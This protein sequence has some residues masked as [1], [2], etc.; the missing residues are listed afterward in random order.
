MLLVCNS[1][2][3][4]ENQKRSNLATVLDAKLWARPKLWLLCTI[5]LCERHSGLEFCPTHIPLAQAGLLLPV[6]HAGRVPRDM[7]RLQV[8]PPKV[9]RAREQVHRNFSLS[10]CY[11]DQRK[12]GREEGG[13]GDEKRSFGVPGVRRDVVARA[14]SAPVLLQ[15]KKGRFG[16]FY[17]GESPLASA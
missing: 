5:L 11:V 16:G 12:P 6:V 17:C 1:L 3:L 15:A 7:I 13:I 4:L 8:E 10:I 2:R 14:S 9:L